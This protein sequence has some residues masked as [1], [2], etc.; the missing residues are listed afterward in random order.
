[1]V[2]PKGKVIA[3]LAVF[4]ALVLVAASGAFTSVQAERTAAVDVASDADAFL[5]LAA[6][7]SN[8]NGIAYASDGSGANDNQL[9]VNLTSTMNGGSGV[10]ENAVT[11]ADHVF[12]I[13]NQGTQSVTVYLEPAGNA[14]AGVLAFYHNGTTAAPTSSGTITGSTNAVTLGTGEKVTVGV[15]VDTRGYDG[16]GFTE[17]VTVY[18]EAV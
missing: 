7:T 5:A 2:R 16:G 18:A 15:K 14:P 10:N 13:Q 11:T 8:N 9:S 4:T 12:D 6:N 1:M 3:L 17:Q